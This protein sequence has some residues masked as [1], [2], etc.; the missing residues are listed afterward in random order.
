[1]EVFQRSTVVDILL[2]KRSIYRLLSEREREREVRAV[3]ERTKEKRK[4]GERKM[5]N[6]SAPSRMN[7]NR[8]N[9]CTCMDLFENIDPHI[10]NR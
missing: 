3:E 2:K 1:M 7:G 4:G 5:V 10:V 9:E 8:V 6:F